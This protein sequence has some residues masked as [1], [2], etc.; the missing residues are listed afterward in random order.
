[1]SSRERNKAMPDVPAVA[2]YPGLGGFE[3]DLWYGLLAPAGTNPSIVEGLAQKTAE[4][5]KDPAVRARF[6][7]FGT[8]LV[9]STPAEFSTVIKSEIEDGGP[10]S[11]EVL[12]VSP[13]VPSNER[14]SRA[15]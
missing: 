10:Y 5:F 12:V 7:P 3:S 6:E 9:G 15:N 11:P 1:V 13:S 2:E 14:S 4:A 8:V